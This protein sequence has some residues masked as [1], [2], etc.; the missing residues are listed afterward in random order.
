MPSFFDGVP[1]E[2]PSHRHGFSINRIDSRSEERDETTAKTALA[3]PGAAVYLLVEDQAVLPDANDRPPLFTV[4]A[5]RSLG[6]DPDRMVFLGWTEGGPRFAAELPNEDALAGAGLIARPLRSVA[7]EGLVEPHHLGGFAQGM[8]VP[9]G[10]CAHRSL[11][12]T[13]FDLW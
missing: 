7:I 8:V 5:A 2:D 1:A 10:Q 12:L 13:C 3:D 11:V 4:E 9:F 6:A